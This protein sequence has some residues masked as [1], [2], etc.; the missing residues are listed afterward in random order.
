[1]NLLDFTYLLTTGLD[2][3]F[4]ICF[5]GFTT[6]GCSWTGGSGVGSGVGDFGGVGGGVSRSNSFSDDGDSDS[7]LNF[8]KIDDLTSFTLTG[9]SSGFSST[10]NFF[11]CNQR[12]EIFLNN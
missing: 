10:V 9:S 6:L 7:N 1:M 5:S 3:S 8:S 2:T 4:S 11:F 12:Y